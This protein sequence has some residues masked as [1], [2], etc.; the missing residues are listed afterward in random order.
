ML[1]PLTYNLCHCAVLLVGLAGVLVTCCSY[2]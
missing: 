2:C 1:R